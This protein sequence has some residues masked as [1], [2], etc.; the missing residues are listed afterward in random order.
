MNRSRPPDLATFLAADLRLRHVAAGAP[1]RRATSAADEP[2]LVAPRGLGLGV[3]A[4]VVLHAL[5]L[6]LAAFG[7]TRAASSPAPDPVAE[8]VVVLADGPLPEV[9]L[10]TM[11]EETTIVAERAPRPDDPSIPPHASGDEPTPRPDLARAGRG[12][13]RE[14]T[15]PAVNLAAHDDAIALAR[16]MQSRLDRSQIP[17]IDAGDHRASLDDRRATLQ[18][19]EVT[20]LASGHG[21]RAERRPVAEHDP[22]RGARASGLPGTLGASPGAEPLPAGEGESPRDAGSKRAG[23]SV[24]S[25]GAGTITAALGT[26]HHASAD[27]AFARPQ[28]AEGRPAVPALTKDKPKDTVDSAQEVAA[29]TQSLLDASTAGGRKG[30][31]PGGDGSGGTPGAGGREGPGSNAKVLGQGAGSTVDLDG[32]DRRLSDYRRGVTS[33]IH[34]LWKD[35]FPKWAAFEGRQGRAIIHFVIQADGSLTDVSVARESGIPEFDANVMSAVRRA[36]PFPPI[37]PKLGAPMQFWLT[38]DSP[39]PAVR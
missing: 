24:A 25:P 3:S 2:R 7:L 38:F 19:M 32:L 33:K 6:G 34:P 23:G 36:G 10:P 4:S 18:P 35:A 28:V 20:F 29:S 30:E 12:G 11:S 13:T 14:V 21:E 31:G 37:P 26:S 5:V 1:R 27:V 39:N 17:R 15:S 8:R 9:E 16:S 22:S